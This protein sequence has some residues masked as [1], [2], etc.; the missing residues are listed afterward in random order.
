MASCKPMAR[1]K[2]Q[3]LYASKHELKRREQVK[4]LWFDAGAIASKFR[5]RFSTVSV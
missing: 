2:A 5:G 4:R 3:P 1:H